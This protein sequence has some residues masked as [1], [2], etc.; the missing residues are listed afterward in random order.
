M[1][2]S[3]ALSRWPDHGIGADHNNEDVT[4]LPKTLF[5]NLI[6]LKLQQWIC[7]MKDIDP[8]IDP[9]Y[10]ALKQNTPSTLLPDLKDW[11]MEWIDDD[12]VL[13]YKNKLYIPKDLALR[14]DIWRCSMTMKLLDTLVNSRP[15]IQSGCTTGGLDY[16][17]LSRTMWKDVDPVNN[18]KLTGPHLTLPWC[19]FNLQRLQDPLPIAL[20]IWS[21]TSHLSTTLTPSWSQ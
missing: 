15:T 12:D 10:L 8:S 3:D 17:L 14:Q 5:V 16:G 20:W 6:D 7:K 1:I 2:L 13:Y 11:K 21:Q 19:P 9:V 18:S 4:L